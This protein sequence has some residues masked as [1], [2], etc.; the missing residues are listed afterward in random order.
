M[1]TDPLLMRL[2]THSATRQRIIALFTDPDQQH[3]SRVPTGLLTPQGRTNVT[4]SLSPVLARHCPSLQQS[5]YAAELGGGIRARPQSN[6]WLRTSR[7]LGFL[8]RI[9]GRSPIESMWLDLW[10]TR[11]KIL[12]LPL[13][14]RFYVSSL[15]VD[16]RSLDLLWFFFSFLSSQPRRATVQQQHQAGIVL[17]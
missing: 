4:R 5:A 2:I 8:D 3:G 14:C 13:W 6:E 11:I 17:L 7:G 1:R 15:G 9:T 10:G 16:I 12:L